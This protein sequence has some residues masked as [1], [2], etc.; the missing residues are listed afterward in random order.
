MA[1]VPGAPGTLGRQREKPVLRDR[2]KIKGDIDRFYL[3]TDIK[4]KE[5]N[6]E[7][8]MGWMLEQMPDKYRYADQ[9]KPDLVAERDAQMAQRL[10][11]LK[12]KLSDPLNEHWT[13]CIDYDWTDV[14]NMRWNCRQ[15]L[16]KKEN[17]MIDRHIL[18][19][20]HRLLYRDKQLEGFGP[21]SKKQLR[22]TGCFYSSVPLEDF[23]MKSGP[24]SFFPISN[25][26]SPADVSE[27]TLRSVLQ[28][29]SYMMV[30]P[31]S[32]CF[33]HALFFQSRFV[34]G[35]ATNRY[36]ERLYCVPGYSDRGFIYNVETMEDV[37]QGLQEVGDKVQFRA[38]DLTRFQYYGVTL[39]QTVVDTADQLP[40]VTGVPSECRI[41]VGMLV[42]MENHLEHA[43][44]PG[45]T[46]TEHNQHSYA[47]LRWR[48]IAAV[49]ICHEFVHAIINYMHYPPREPFYDGHSMSETGWAWEQTVFGGIATG[50]LNV[51]VDQPEW[52]LEMIKWPDAGSWGNNY[53]ERNKMWQDH[54]MIRRLPKH[55]QTIFYIRVNWL[56]RTMQDAFWNSIVKPSTPESPNNN[57][58]A[59]FPPRTIGY[60]EYWVVPREHHDPNWR[61]SN[62]S[63]RHSVDSF[64]HIIRNPALRDMIR[65]ETTKNNI[66]PWRPTSEEYMAHKK[67]VHFGC[68]DVA[69][70]EVWRAVNPEEAVEEDAEW[71]A[72]MAEED[73]KNTKSA[74]DEDDG[75]GFYWFDLEDETGDGAG[76]PVQSGILFE[77]G[78][79]TTGDDTIAMD[80]DEDEDEDE[81]MEED[82]DEE[83]KEDD[84]TENE[85]MGEEE[86][87]QEREEEEEEEVETGGNTD[88]DI[89]GG[90]D[91][92]EKD[93]END[94]DGGGGLTTN[95]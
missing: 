44:R 18:Q 35:V 87:E 92:D 30:C 81:E 79:E 29:T 48:W 7:E 69:E 94:E 45:I 8:L 27:K 22:D 36:K 13:F 4:S 67:A 16:F 53:I 90:S 24:F 49:T 68:R 91:E 19:Q 40:T 17:P 3:R 86:E 59:L 47:A 84:E 43:Q 88:E 5:F 95:A 11:E 89:G 15:V 6:D 1:T 31:A 82:Q 78:W 60:R 50:N 85:N 33:L 42:K 61:A 25:W 9:D 58:K 76:V 20:H 12:E 10:P 54:V 83:M 73:K 28:L 77:P 65:A 14:Q 52:P 37:R 26:N 46:Q 74:E 57:W 56:R 75:K 70:Y 32:V 62:S 51:G 63:E 93:G 66:T 41:E 23:N 34:D 72:S 38:V 80:N 39:G 2:P 55:S 64:G 21:Y 71:K